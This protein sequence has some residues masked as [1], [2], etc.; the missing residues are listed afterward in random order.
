ML[1]TREDVVCQTI[2]ISQEGGSGLRWGYLFG[3]LKYNKLGFWALFGARQKVWRFAE[4][5]VPL[6][7]NSPKWKWPIY[8]PLWGESDYTLLY[9]Y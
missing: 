8:V 4:I 5:V 7:S 9:I 2:I 6:H 1:R 3:M